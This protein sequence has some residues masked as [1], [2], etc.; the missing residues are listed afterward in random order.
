LTGHAAPSNA[1]LAAFGARDAP[2]ALPGGSAKAY[3]ASGVVFKRGQDENFT[4][5]L[6]EVAQVVERQTAFRFACPVRSISGAWTVE[7]WSASIQLAGR[8]EP[9]RWTDILSV[10]RA[11]HRAVAGVPCPPFQGARTD[12]WALGDR[13]AWGECEVA[14]PALLQEQVSAT[15]ALRQPIE[16]PSQLVHGDLCG[17]VLFAPA[18]P[19]ALLDF[20]P[21]FRPAEYA[22]AILVADAIVWEG[23]PAELVGALRRDTAGQMLVRASLFRLYTAAV[24]WSGKPLRLTTIGEQHKQFTRLLQT[25]VDPH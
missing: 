15:A 21:Y 8:H 24:A 2:V 16:L 9:G 23:A 25:L 3:A 10:G 19:P 1:I 17:N 5:W 14:V 12:Q 6:A 4:A 18:L 13:A 11:L 22:E 7:G 20:S